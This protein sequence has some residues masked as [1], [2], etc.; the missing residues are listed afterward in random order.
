M[1]LQIQKPNAIRQNIAGRCSCYAT[2]IVNGSESH[3]C[4]NEKLIAFRT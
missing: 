4:R 1:T 3:G 2:I